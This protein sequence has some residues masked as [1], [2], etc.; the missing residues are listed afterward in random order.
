MQALPD[1]W[2]EISIAGSPA[3]TLYKYRI[4]GELE[5]PDPGLAL[6]AA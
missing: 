2:Y 6:P 1:G 3:G 4:D 5:V